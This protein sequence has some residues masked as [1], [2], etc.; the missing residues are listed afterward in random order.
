MRFLDVMNSTPVLHDIGV[1]VVS[2]L[3]NS[4][5]N[6]KDDDKFIHKQKDPQSI[7]RR[8]FSRDNDEE[9]AKQVDA[10]VKNR[11]AYGY[12]YI[13]QPLTFLRSS[14]YKW[15]P[16]SLEYYKKMSLDR[17]TEWSKGSCECSV[18]KKEFKPN[19]ILKDKVL[20]I[21]GD[22]ES[23]REYFKETEDSKKSFRV[24]R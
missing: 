14:E 24:K 23:W 6:I 15:L 19:T 2:S 13:R 17:Y 5:I 3:V 1:L 16:G 8:M 22:D 18:C 11:E 9:I 20:D 7:L 4:S 21:F 10:M 12:G